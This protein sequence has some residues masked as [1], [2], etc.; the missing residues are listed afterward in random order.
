MPPTVALS[1]LSANGQVAAQQLENE[2]NLAVEEAKNKGALERQILDNQNQINIEAFKGQVQ[3]YVSD[4]NLAAAQLETVAKN[5]AALL[6]HNSAIHGADAQRFASAFA[7]AVKAAEGDPKKLKKIIE[8]MGENV[9]GWDAQTAPST[10][11]NLVSSL[12]ALGGVS[13]WARPDDDPLAQYEGKKWEGGLT[14][15]KDVLDALASGDLGFTK[16]DHGLLVLTTDNTAFIPR[17]QL[18]PAMRNL[19]QESIT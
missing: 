4:N 10:T 1:T 8:A 18:P 2:G 9:P 5:L 15:D 16:D 14:G 11:E 19:V 7:A 13:A 3:K 12:Q 17:N 6:E